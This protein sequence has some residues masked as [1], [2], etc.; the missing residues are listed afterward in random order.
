[1]AANKIIP[2]EQEHEKSCYAHMLSKDTAKINWRLSAKEIKNL[3]RGL[4][5]WPIAYTQYENQN[6]K[7]YDSEII[8]IKTSHDPGY[9]INVSKNGIQVSTGEGVLLI[10]TIQFPG[11]KPLKVEEYIKGNSI[12]EGVILM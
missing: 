1:L 10:K 6:M 12:K 9:I 7:I 3:I 5:P 8:N 2:I 11:G 4:N